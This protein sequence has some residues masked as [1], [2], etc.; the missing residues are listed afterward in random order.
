MFLRLLRYSGGLGIASLR[1][2][3]AA[4]KQQNN[5]VMMEIMRRGCSDPGE[6]LPRLLGLSTGAYFFSHDVMTAG[7]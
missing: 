2:S 4:Q 6:D 7:W 5:Y 1:A 3:F